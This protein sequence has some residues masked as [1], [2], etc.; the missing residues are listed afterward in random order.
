[1]KS[2][3]T[4]RELA[5][6]I[7]V[8][9]SSV[10]RWVDAGH[11][12][13]TRTQGGHRRIAIDDALRYLREIQADI[14][15]PQVLGLEHFAIAGAEDQALLAALSAG[16]AVSARGILLSLYVSGRHVSRIFDGPV[17]SVLAKLGDHG[18][19]DLAATLVEHRAMD[20]CLQAVCQL[21]SLLIP[22]A[23]APLAIGAAP[24]GDPSTLPSMMVAAVLADA[25]FREA[26]LGPNTPVEPLGQLATEKKARLVW[27]SITTAPN[28]EKLLGEIDRLSRTLN[29]QK[30]PLVLGGRIVRD[31]VV[32]D[33]PNLHVVSTMAELAAF[34]RGITAGV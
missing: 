11:I 26:N 31:F 9:E 14:P 33:R 34:A 19:R 1:M 6:A 27:L 18:A 29:E 2:L 13:M 8:S 30:I 7:G 32:R 23:D 28:A 24:A 22:P 20:I 17:R 25:G 12:P 10:R 21:R 4:P 15:R 16:D 5:D 3:L